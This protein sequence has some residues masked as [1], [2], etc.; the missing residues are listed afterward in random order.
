MELQEELNILKSENKQ[1]KDFLE[2]INAEKIALDQ[3]LVESLKN[4]LSAK[5]DVILKDEKIR[6]LNVELD[7]IKKEKE[8]LQKQLDDLNKKDDELNL[9]E[10]AA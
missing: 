9:E 1:Y 10:L 7:V 4:N 8:V 3:L 5:K 6:K 2:G